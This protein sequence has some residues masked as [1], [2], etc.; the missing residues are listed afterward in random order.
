MCTEY[1]YFVGRAQAFLLLFCFTL[2]YVLYVGRHMYTCTL[3][4]GHTTPRMNL[5]VICRLS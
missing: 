4:V 2:F 1:V 5:I 3:C